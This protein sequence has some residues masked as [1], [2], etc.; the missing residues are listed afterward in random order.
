MGKYVALLRGINV[1]GNNKVSMADLKACFEA[2]GFTNVRTYINSGNVLFESPETDTRKLAAMLEECIGDQ[3]GDYKPQVLVCTHE[4]LR[5]I[6]QKAPEGF[7][8]Q[9]GKYRY[10]VIFIMPP[11]TAAEAFKAMPL[12]E[13]V[14]EATVGEGVVYHSRLE[15]RATQSWLNKIVGTPNY[16]H[17]TIRNWNT[18]TKL[19]SL[20]KI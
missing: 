6:V 10:N 8:A 3:F 18:T 17:M 19:L 15:A 14:D 4:Q 20:L 1:G 13:G 7:G 12:R 5:S 16:Q 11:L 9:P 2:A